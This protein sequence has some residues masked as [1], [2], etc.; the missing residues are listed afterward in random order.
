MPKPRALILTR[1]GALDPSARLRLLQFAPGFRQA[2][3]DIDHQAFL[4]SQDL[5]R[6]YASGQ[7]DWLKLMHAYSRRLLH[8]LAARRYDIIWVQRELFPYLPG[9]FEQF[10]G[11]AAQR[12]IVDYDDAVFHRYEQHPRRLVRWLLGRKLR[13]LLSRV[14]L[15]TACSQYLCAHLVQRG[16]RRTAQVPT[17]IDP[18]R[19]QLLTQEPATRR[20]PTKGPPLRI[21]WIGSPTTTPYLAELVPVLREFGTTRPIRLVTIGAAPFAAGGLQ[22]EAH[23]WSEQ[24]ETRLLASI[25]IGVM[26]LPSGPWEHGKCG[27]KLIQYMACAKPV[28]AS[29]VG[30][31]PEV[32]TPDTGFVVADPR[33]WLDALRRLS[34]APHLRQCMGRAGQTRV[35]AHYSTQQAL[36][37][38]LALMET[39]ASS[40]SSARQASR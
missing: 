24:T 23:A 36:P 31:N 12:C 32:V 28:I 37:Q 14:A 8:L 10:I 17:V 4:D 26:P 20:E 1:Y 18:A 27:Y 9:A 7:R 38:L 2:G 21:G 30:V 6:L 35:L 34:D 13:P 5:Q 19:Y 16:A 11:T 15:V 39:V 22:V 25:D 29:A 33:G 40:A 3:W